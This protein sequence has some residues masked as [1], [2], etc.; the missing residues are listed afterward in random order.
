MLGNIHSDTKVIRKLFE[1][2][3]AVVTGMTRS[4]KSVLGPIVCSFQ[5]SERYFM[6]HVFEQ[7]PMLNGIGSMSDEIAVYLLRHSFD[8]MTYDNMIGRNSNF[9]FN[10][11][12]SIW[13]TNDPGIYF[14]RLN[15]SEGDSVYEKIKK[16]KPLFVL[17]L[18]NG[19]MYASILF[20]AFPSLKM[21][22]I[23]RH[24]IDLVHSWYLKKYGDNFYENPRVACLTIK[25]KENILPFYA[26]GWEK[27]YLGLSEMDRI[28]HLI[29]RLIKGHEEVYESLSPKYKKQVMIVPF[30]ELVTDPKPYLEKICDFLDTEE[31]L[32]TPIKLQQE[33][34]PRTLNESDRLKKRDEIKKLSSEDAFNLLEHMSKKYESTNSI[35]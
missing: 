10:D 22:H 8:V 15:A 6:D 7:F 12:S 1:K 21:I 5:R 26:A 34:C 11:F 9:R 33:R 13:K 27:K 4:G 28:I 30:E 31:T 16:E 3:L 18:H 14:S 20:K 32:Y 23:K 29:S 19:L 25:W 17:N 24:P 35:C 2:D